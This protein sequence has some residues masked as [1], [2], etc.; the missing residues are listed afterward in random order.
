MAKDLEYLKYLVPDSIRQK[1]E[2][3]SVLP[4]LSTIREAA[5]LPHQLPVHNRSN[6]KGCVVHPDVEEVVVVPIVLG[7]ESHS[8]MRWPGKKREVVV[9]GHAQ[10][11]R[12]IGRMNLD[13][14]FHFCCLAC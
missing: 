8:G 6:L 11:V 5:C 4:N 3:L 1:R 10:G 13:A 9:E 12:L 14:K 7:I 2:I